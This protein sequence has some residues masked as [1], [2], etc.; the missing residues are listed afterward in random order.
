MNETTKIQLN[1]RS[2]RE[3]LPN[4]IKKEVLAE[5]FAV[6]NQTA[7]SAN[8][9]AASIIQIVNPT[10]K[11][12]VAE[13]CQAPELNDV[14]GLV[15]FIV[16]F[17]RNN[18]ILK[19]REIK[20]S[21][22]NQMGS[23]FQG[24]TEAALMAQNFM[25]ALESHGLGGC[26]YGSILNDVKR[27]VELVNLPLLTFPVV[28]LGFGEIKQTE[29]PRQ[30]LQ[31]EQRIFTDSYPYELDYQSYQPTFHQ[32]AEKRSSADDQLFDFSEI[33]A[34]RLIKLNPRR[35]EIL[36]QIRKQGFVGF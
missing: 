25:L 5:L 9:Q 31:V 20:A 3:L 2:Y 28:A 7:T 24:F 22:I 29:K 19:A 1:H 6:A 27:L 18:E 14:P 34:K 35:N 4:P 26:F 21:Q 23:F 30:R 13:I 32:V 10:R 36:K 12:V 8:L 11:A 33:L 15:L 16:D 17:Y